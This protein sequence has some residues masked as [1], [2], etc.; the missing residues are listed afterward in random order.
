MSVQIPNLTNL[1]EGL[2]KNIKGISSAFLKLEFNHA[3]T[4]KDA[5]VDDVAQQ[6]IKEALPKNQAGLLVTGALED[7]LQSCKKRVETIAKQCRMTNRR[8]R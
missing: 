4:A 5:P 6:A 1:A 2:K 3:K 7:A 8:F